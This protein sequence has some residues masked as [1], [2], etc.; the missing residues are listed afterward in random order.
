MKP[1]KGLPREFILEATNALVPII[2]KY[3]DM[4]KSHMSAIRIA[5]LTDEAA[6]VARQQVYNW[7]KK[8]EK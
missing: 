3:K 7:G 1:R 2:R 8:Q 5:L 4:K 6:F